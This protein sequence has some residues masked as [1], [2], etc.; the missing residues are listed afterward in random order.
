[1]QP[2]ETGEKQCLYSKTSRAAK[3]GSR[4]AAV[5]MCKASFA[6][7]HITGE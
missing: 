6:G 1:M 5:S 2:P 7:S 3:P 4:E